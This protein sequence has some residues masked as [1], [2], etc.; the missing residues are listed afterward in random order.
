MTAFLTGGFDAEDFVPGDSTFYETAYGTG[1]VIQTLPDDTPLDP[2]TDYFVKI[3]ARDVD[4]SAS[5]SA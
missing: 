5:P 3:V 1:C 4:G 2:M